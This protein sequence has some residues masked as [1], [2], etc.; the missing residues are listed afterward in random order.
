M[1]IQPPLELP[2]VLECE[3]DNHPIGAQHHF[4]ASLR[5]GE[6]KLNQLSIKHIVI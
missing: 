2:V 5:E 3:G 6:A 1:E 4:S